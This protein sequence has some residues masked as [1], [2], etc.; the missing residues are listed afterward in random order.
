MVITR[1]K[2]ENC[3]YQGCW[4]RYR[5][6]IGFRNQKGGYYA[7]KTGKLLQSRLLNPIKIE[8][9]WYEIW[10]LRQLPTPFYV[11]VY[12][13]AFTLNDKRKR[14][15]TTSAIFSRIKTLFC[16]ESQSLEL[17]PILVITKLASTSATCRLTSAP[18]ILKTSST[19]SAKSPTLIWKIEEDLLSLSSNLKIPGKKLTLGCSTEG[20]LHFFP[21]FRRDAEDAVHARD[22]YDYDGYRLRVEFPRGSQNS[23]G[24]GGGGHR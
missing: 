24:G 6:L 21:P 4:T 19:N 10:Q 8:L 3:L 22:G 13:L 17:C 23:G 2:W 5:S 12:F 14:V 16:S 20:S 18:K 9:L 15:L 7:R 1:G 11:E